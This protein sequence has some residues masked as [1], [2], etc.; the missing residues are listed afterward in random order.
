[1]P[2]KIR[3]AR[4]RMIAALKDADGNTGFDVVFAR[5]VNGETQE[6]IART[7]GLSQSAL[8]NLIRYARKKDPEV[9]ERWDAAKKEKA[10]R[11]RDQILPIIDHVKPVKAEPGE[12]Q[13]E[14]RDAIA[15]ARERVDARLQ[16]ANALDPVDK[17]P[18]VQINIGDSL[19]R[20]IQAVAERKKALPPP[21][22]MK[23][24]IVPE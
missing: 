23:A 9:G 5:L 6:E 15:L 7:M 18:P 16:L 13:Q 2:F 3:R 4:E 11:I 17:T 19:V 22:P 24:E 1:M 21:E 20:A 14:W 10:D 8:S 12:P